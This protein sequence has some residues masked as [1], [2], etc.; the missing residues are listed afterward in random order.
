MIDMSMTPVVTDPHKSD[1]HMHETHGHKTSS[2]NGEKREEEGGREKNISFTQ[3]IHLTFL[4]GIFSDDCVVS[5]SH[6]FEG[7]IHETRGHKTRTSSE[8]GEER[9]EEEHRGRKAERSGI[10]FIY[11]GDDVAVGIYRR[12]FVVQ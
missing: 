10:T 12:L 8:H 2:E 3:K 4:L 5:V 11:S 6:N 9:E 7:H 1:R